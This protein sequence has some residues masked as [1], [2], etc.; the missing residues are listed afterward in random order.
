M[1]GASKLCS[2]KLFVSANNLSGAEGTT[3]SVVRYGNVIGSRGSVIP[4]FLKHKEKGKIP[5]TD[6]RMTRFWISL[7]D[8]VKFVYNSLKIMKG[9]EIFIPKIPSMKIVD[10]ANAIAPECRQILTGV[11]PG[12]KIHETMI[13]VDDASRT[14]E[15]NDKYIICPEK[16]LVN[17]KSYIKYSNMLG[18]KVDKKFKYDSHENSDW[19]TVDQLRR[20]VR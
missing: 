2:D 19:F 14:I 5:I 15:F 6:E 8:G 7:E 3:F 9:G 17:D 13:P 10:L 1:Y 4:I 12:E 16:K 18:K 20:I 11:R